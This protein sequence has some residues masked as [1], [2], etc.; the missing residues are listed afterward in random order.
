MLT[1]S[2]QVI[3]RLGASSAERELN[4]M[5]GHPDSS[6][7]NYDQGDMPFMLD[8]NTTWSNMS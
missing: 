1:K 7:G 6:L 2:L 3:P 5:I 8:I 4:G